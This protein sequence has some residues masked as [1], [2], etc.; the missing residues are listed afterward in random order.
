VVYVPELKLMRMWYR[1]GGWGFPTGVG[2]ADSP[3]GG[4]T[5][6]KYAGN[7]VWG[8]RGVPG[9][10]GGQPWVYREG[11]GLYWLYTT[12][13]DAHGGG[14]SAAMQIAKSSD[15]LSWTNVSVGAVPLPSAHDARPAADRLVT[16]TMFGNR[17]VWK[18]AEGTWHML[19][20]GSPATCLLPRPA[21]R[22][23]TCIENEGPLAPV[24]RSAG[25]AKAYGKYSSTLGALRPAGAYARAHCARCN[26]TRAAC[27]AAATSRRLTASTRRK[28][29]APAATASGTMRDR[30]ATCPQ[31]VSVRCFESA[32]PH[33]VNSGTA[34]LTRAAV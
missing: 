9:E 14:D 4:K 27:L 32:R 28:T 13:S 17:A 8:A 3:D 25:Q 23:A 20:V 10:A 33:S 29:P 7:P 12:Y 2:V 18:E 6:W 5:W 11:S 16:G 19:Q 1:G 26:A 22:S 30:T 21:F 34:G 24:C 15:G 31:T